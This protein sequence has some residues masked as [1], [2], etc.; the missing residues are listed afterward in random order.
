MSERAGRTHA[1]Q[2]VESLIDEMVRTGHDSA[3]VSVSGGD[4]DEVVLDGGFKVHV[5]AAAIRRVEGMRSSADR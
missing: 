4:D 1:E 5:L 2:F 3:Y